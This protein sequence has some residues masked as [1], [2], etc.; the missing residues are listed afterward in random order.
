MLPP[1]VAVC[2][3]S[4]NSNFAQKI[5]WKE[6]GIFSDTSAHALPSSF[7]ELHIKA[8]MGSYVIFTFSI[9][10]N[11]LPSLTAETF[12]SG[13]MLNANLGGAVVFEMTTSSIKCKQAVINGSDV[14]PISYRVLYR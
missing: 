4:Q 11:D 13:Y 7:S 14:L 8:N 1:F 6:L 2:A 12:R 9:L 5:A 3:G 10:Y